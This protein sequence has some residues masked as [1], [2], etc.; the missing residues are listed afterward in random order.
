MV[1]HGADMVAKA[2]DSIAGQTG[3]LEWAVGLLKDVAQSRAGVDLDPKIWICFLLVYV[4]CALHV[5]SGQVRRSRGF[6]VAMCRCKA[7]N[8]HN[9]AQLYSLIDS[10]A[11]RVLAEAGRNS[12][13]YDPKEVCVP[14]PNVH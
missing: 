12:A 5:R 9:S 7:D 4:Y 6:Y 14:M 13:R 1:T 2:L 11:P 10:L 3:A 8:Y